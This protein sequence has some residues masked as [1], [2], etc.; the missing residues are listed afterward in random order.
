MSLKN[1]VL[2]VEHEWVRPEAAA[3][4]FILFLR[5]HKFSVLGRWLRRR[6]LIQS[7]RVEFAITHWY[8]LVSIAH[9][10]IFTRR[11]I[12]L[13][14]GV[15]RYLLDHRLLVTFLLQRGLRRLIISATLFLILQIHL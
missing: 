2:V 12:W 15:R 5:V 1:Q 10:F 9:L 3:K 13:L 7:G 14:L 8:D 4:S 11:G 6:L